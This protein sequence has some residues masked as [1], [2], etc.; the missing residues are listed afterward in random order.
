MIKKKLIVLIL[1][2]TFIIISFNFSVVSAEQSDY[3]FNINKNN[4]VLSVN[5]SGTLQDSNITNLYNQ[6][7]RNMISRYSNSYINV[8]Y[9]FS[10]FSIQVAY[11]PTSFNDSS[12]NNFTS[13]V[14]S[15]FQR[16]VK[17]RT[18][19]GSG[20]LPASVVDVK[21]LDYSNLNFG[22]ICYRYNWG[23]SYVLTLT[24]SFSFDLKLDS[25]LL[26]SSSSSSEYT[27]SGIVIPLIDSV[28]DKGGF[29]Y[30]LSQFITGSIGENDY[31][32]TYTFP[33]YL[34][35][36]EYI[37]IY[38]EIFPYATNDY[39]LENASFSVNNNVTF[40]GKTYTYNS[41]KAPISRNSLLVKL[42]DNTRVKTIEYY[43]H[44][45]NDYSSY[46]YTFDVG[47]EMYLQITTFVPF[48]ANSSSSFIQQDT[49][50]FD[51]LQLTYYEAEWYEIHKQ[52]ANGFI[53]IITELPIVSDVTN[54]IYSMFMYFKQSMN[55][56]TNFSSLGYIFAFGMFTIVFG[57]LI[58]F[59][60]GS[61]ND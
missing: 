54:A 14:Y 34:D 38:D 36:V 60:G 7:Y 18:L 49:N 59:I 22:L 26:T 8:R 52:L 44:K 61:T 58:K 9:N 56:L 28:F 4:N 20:Q 21:N 25:R 46:V 30:N 6:G 1:L 24:G 41:D 57:I 10:N 17:Q 12:W 32:L 33:D 29:T 35:N 27:D 43:H 15:E 23:Y 11:T 42:K 53:F 51:N 19:G 47:S 40:N 13:F 48:F 37:Y 31:Y 45:N 3:I 39:F 50:N 55:I 5:Y 16:I 2:L